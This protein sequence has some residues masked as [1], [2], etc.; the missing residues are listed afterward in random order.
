MEYSKPLF[1]T[2][3]RVFAIVAGVKEADLIA[4]W[5]FEVSLAPE[6]GTIRRVFIK[7]QAL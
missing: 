1:Y 4:V 2:P 6:P 5:V 7:A 3:G